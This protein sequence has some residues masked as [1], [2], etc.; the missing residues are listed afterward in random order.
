MESIELTAEC[1]ICV[2]VSRSL[3][4]G[5]V[6]NQDGIWLLAVIGNSPPVTTMGVAIISN[7]VLSGLGR[8]IGSRLGLSC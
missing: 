5:W 2:K 1:P 6:L 7:W 4:V 3:S 8:N